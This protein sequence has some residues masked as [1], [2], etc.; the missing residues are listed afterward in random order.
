MGRA[1]LFLLFLKLVK[2]AA[3][4]A[5]RFDRGFSPAVK[6]S[7]ANDNEIVTPDGRTAIESNL[8]SV[9]WLGD[10]FKI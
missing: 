1:D 6:F 10:S 9:G 8:F 5:D 3:E 2:R 7:L 4:A